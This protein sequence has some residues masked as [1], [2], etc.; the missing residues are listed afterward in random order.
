[1]RRLAD[2]VFGAPEPSWR[3]FIGYISFLAIAGA[4]FALYRR[5]WL[6]SAV[7]AVVAAVGLT[8]AVCLQSREPTDLVVELPPIGIHYL[9]P[10]TIIGPGLLVAGIVTAD[11]MLAILGTVTAILSAVGLWLAWRRRR[12]YGA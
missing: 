7:A 5:A 9:Y 4:G 2:A 3:H 10:W 12:S 11:L 8:A 6:I 1:V